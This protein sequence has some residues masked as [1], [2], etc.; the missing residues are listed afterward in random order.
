LIS[1]LPYQLQRFY[2][3]FGKVLPADLV[4]RL[5]NIDAHRQQVN[6]T[7]LTKYVAG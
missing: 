4:N 7:Q 5:V 2:A 1:Y 3:D 6:T